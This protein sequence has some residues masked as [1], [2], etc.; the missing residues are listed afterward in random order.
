MRV[1]SS[2][3]LGLLRRLSCDARAPL[4][5]RDCG[6]QRA[7]A[8]RT[9]R[10]KFGRCPS[11]TLREIPCPA[12]QRCP[13][14]LRPRP[15]EWSTS[16]HA[17]VPSEKGR[18]LL[19]QGRAACACSAAAREKN[20]GRCAD[21]S[22]APAENEAPSMAQRSVRARAVILDTMKAQ[23]GGTAEASSVSGRAR[24]ARPARGST[25]AQS[26]GIVGG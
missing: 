3:P 11:A 26:T 16:R 23:S 22:D 8:G 4:R 18:G 10:Q 15:R 9:R 20:G 24:R 21:I 19:P 17:H 2:L 7:R 13:F 12:Q 25:R 6:R 1:P 5:Q 14:F